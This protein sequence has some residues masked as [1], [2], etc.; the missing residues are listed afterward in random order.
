MG[1][2]KMSNIQFRDHE[3]TNRTGSGGN[4]DYSLFGDISG[5]WSGEFTV[6]ATMSGFVVEFLYSQGELPH[7]NSISLNNNNILRYAQVEGSD[8]NSDWVLAGSS[9]L[10]FPMSTIFLF[11]TFPSSFPNM[12]FKTSGNWK[13]ATDGY[14][15]V[16]GEWKKVKKIHT[17]IDSNWV[18]L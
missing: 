15:K 7:I 12:K 2:G 3:N 4:F 1:D 5:S 18:E 16:N 13:S 10:M 9:Q 8:N 17:K 6:T 11:Q 14:Y